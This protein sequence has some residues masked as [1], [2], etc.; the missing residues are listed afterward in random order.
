[1]PFKHQILF[2]LFLGVDK[3]AMHTNRECY[4]CQKTH[5]T[6]G[7]SERFGGPM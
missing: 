2:Y 6:R 3:I 5:G 4:Y 1:M 7:N